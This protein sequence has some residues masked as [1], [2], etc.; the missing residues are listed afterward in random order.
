MEQVKKLLA[1]VPEEDAFRPV[2]VLALFYGLRRSEILGLT[3]ND[4][5]FTAR[6]IH[7]QNTVTKMTTLH[8]S[9]Q[10]KS[11]SSNRILTM[12]PGTESYFEKL[13]AQQKQLYKRIGLPFSPQV[14][15]CAWPDGKP[16]LPEYVSRQFKKILARTGCPRF[17]SMIC[18]IQ[19][20]VCCWRTGWTSKPFS[21]SLGTARL[22][23]H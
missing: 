1:A 19:Q 17:G 11:E 2:I 13:M 21:S 6:T 22:P 20:E 18:A 8:Q 16:F 3:W 7:A 10:T 12:V 4:F 23:L 15:V 9:N 14:P 5:D